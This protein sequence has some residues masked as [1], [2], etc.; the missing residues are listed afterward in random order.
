MS[1]ISLPCCE[2]GQ[3]CR[4][5]GVCNS[6]TAGSALSVRERLTRLYH[7]VQGNLRAYLIPAPFQY[8]IISAKDSYTRDAR[9][10]AGE[11]FSRAFSCPCETLVWDGVFG[12]SHL[13]ISRGHSE[14]PFQIHAN[15]TLPTLVRIGSLSSLRVFLC[16]HRIPP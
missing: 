16:L 2:R 1:T 3:R 11:L 9:M 14:L 4:P 15:L 5:R 13:L 7:A 8:N 12:N 10:P 6:N